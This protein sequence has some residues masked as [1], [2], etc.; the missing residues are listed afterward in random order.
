MKNAIIEEESK[1]ENSDE[2][3]SSNSAGV[4]GA[5]TTSL[6]TSN[7]SNALTN[8]NTF[9][10]VTSQNTNSNTSADVSESLATTPTTSS[11][12]SNTQKKT[13]KPLKKDA[14]SSS[15]SLIARNI[16]SDNVKTTNTKS[17]SNTGPVSVKSSSKSYNSP[18]NSSTV[19]PSPVQE[20]ASFS[21]SANSHNS[22]SKIGH[23]A[24]HSHYSKNHHNGHRS[25][26]ESLG[27]EAVVY[28]VEKSLTM[29]QIREDL[30]SNDIQL[31]CTPRPLMHNDKNS[32]SPVHSIVITLVDEDTFKQCIERSLPI[33]Y[34]MRR[35]KPLRT[36]QRKKNI[37][38]SSFRNGGDW[39]PSK[40][41]SANA[42]GG[43]AESPPSGS[44][45]GDDGSYEENY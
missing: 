27:Y 45:N 42:G 5:K 16:A 21:S 20:Y 17:L 25:T 12:L 30:E 44:E 6:L 4:I 38:G 19:P 37:T 18:S 3:G 10:S 26:P 9:A 31:A 23:N 8:G 35:V 22:N 15:S 11:N 14:N 28:G 34:S 39:V 24:A 32:T 33:N 40:G 36:F 2:N 7:T 13:L 41:S 29:E 1:P 43:N